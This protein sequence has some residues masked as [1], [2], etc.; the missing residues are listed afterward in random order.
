MPWN[1]DKY[2]EFKSERYKPFFDLVSLIKDKPDLKI[3]DLGCGTGELTK[4]L[5]DKLS[6]PLVLGIDNSPE[7]LTKV[8]AQ[9]NLQFKLKSIEDQLKEDTRWD[10]IFA[11]AALQWVDDHATLFSQI[12]S[13]LNP[14]GQLAIQ[15]PC[16]EENILNQIL[17][18]LVQEEPYASALNNWKRISPL[19]SIDEYAELIYKAGGKDLTICQKMYPVIAKTTDDLYDFISGSALIPYFERL[20]ESYQKNLS[21]EFKSRIK[22]NFP[23]MPAIYAFKRLLIY[24]IF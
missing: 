19:L 9:L 17:F 23:E 21:T 12:I 3:L 13:R 1:P 24:A 15:M 20:T 7:M 2:N 22:Q 8:P 6:D 4:L 11:N 16:Q 5:A 14:G 18:E 10:I